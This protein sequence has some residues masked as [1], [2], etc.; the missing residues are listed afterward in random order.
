VLLRFP[1]SGSSPKN[2][3]YDHVI[4]YYIQKYFSIRNRQ[5]AF[6]NKRGLKSGEI[7][8]IEVLWNHSN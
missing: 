4:L 6:R 1:E 7:L 3:D 2:S 8:D 5:S